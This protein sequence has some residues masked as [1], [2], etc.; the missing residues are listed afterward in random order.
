MLAATGEHQIRLCA[1]QPQGAGQSDYLVPAV[2]TQPPAADP[3]VSRA[4]PYQND[5]HQIL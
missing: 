1:T 2:I 4:M 5:V 3:R